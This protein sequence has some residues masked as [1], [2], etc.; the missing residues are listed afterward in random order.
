MLFPIREYT[1]KGH[2][3]MKSTLFVEITLDDTHA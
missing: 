2:S 3:V 1:L